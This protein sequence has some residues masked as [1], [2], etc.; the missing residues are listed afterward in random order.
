VT[1]ID[2][3][4]DMGESFGAYK[5]GEDEKIIEY[6]TSANIACGFH[7]GDPLV[8]DKTVKL[9]RDHGVGVGAHP[10]FPDLIGYGRRYLETFPGEVKQDVLYQVG[11]LSA[12]CRAN[13]VTLQHVKPHG[14]LYNLAARDE[15]VAGEVI[16]AVLAYDPTLILVVLSGSR[17][18]EM[19][20]T[21]GL[22]VAREVFP[23]RAY[24]EDGRLAPRSLPGAVVHDPAQVRRRMVQL[25]TQGTMTS[26]EGRE[27]PLRA[28]TLCI[29][30]DT[31]GAWK[32]A[33]AVREALK[34]AGGTALP[35]AQGLFA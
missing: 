6:I 11:A 1:T 25:L 13:G 32:L 20:E 8:M 31:P 22:Q 4:C 9:A 5:I 27:V 7:A 33:R 17:L 30:G 19:A 10:G 12:F 3:N 18:A 29:H 16:E 2:I 24:L 26:I 28:D 23:D 35:L 34:E 21:A 14:A 15:R